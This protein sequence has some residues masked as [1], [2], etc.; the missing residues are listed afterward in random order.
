MDAQG[1]AGAAYAEMP[2]AAL[3][4]QN[5]GLWAK[6][7][8]RH[9]YETQTLALLRCRELKMCSEPGEGEGDF[10]ARLALRLREARDAELE[11]LRQR[12]AAPLQALRDRIQRAKERVGRERDQYG[13]QQ[14]QTAIS[15]GATVLGAL[16]GRRA[17]SAGT[18]GRATT[19]A[20]GVGRIARERGD[21]ERAE[22]V[23]GTLQQRLQELEH[24]F[25]GE[26]VRLGG[27]LDAATIV[28]EPIVLRP[29]RTDTSAAAPMLVWVP[30][31]TGRSV[32]ER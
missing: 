29:R 8:V 26:K 10:R 14:A 31:E 6:A 20:R 5:Y 25:E 15:F 28:L 30:G 3:R 7:L 32:E 11:R 13:S 18:I 27:A 24:E 2:A 17:V 22:D 12:Y 4:A 1:I 23:L 16:F 21:V 9:A 19:A